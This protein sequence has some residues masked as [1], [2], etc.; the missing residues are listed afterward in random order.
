MRYS[1]TEETILVGIFEPGTT[2]NIKIID[3][4]TDNIIKLNSDVCTP[5]DHI[6]GIYRY[7]TTNIDKN[8]VPAYANLLFC[9]TDVDGNVYYGK[10][11]YGGY[12]DTPVSCDTSEILETVQ[13]I[14]ARM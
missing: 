1:N 9:M 3:L 2:V 7:S 10:F 4:A 6:P 5:S 11:V 8:T 12:L 14:N 13:I